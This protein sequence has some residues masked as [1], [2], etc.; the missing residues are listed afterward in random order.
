MATATEIATRY[1]EA[2]GR[3]DLD[4]A[5]AVWKPGATDRL[6]GDREVTAPDGIRE[7]FGELFA[8]FPDFALRIIQITSGEDRAAVR[9]RSPNAAC[10]ASRVR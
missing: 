4:A 6:V 2:I 7:F 8:A 9:W 5:L 3:Q 10:A 1:F